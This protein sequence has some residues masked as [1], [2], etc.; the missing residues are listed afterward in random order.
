MTKTRQINSNNIIIKA[1]LSRYYKIK[2][3]SIQCELNNIN[4]LILFAYSKSNSNAALQ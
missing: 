4:N 3:L 2:I 1:L